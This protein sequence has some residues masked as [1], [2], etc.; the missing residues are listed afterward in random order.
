MRYRIIVSLV[1]LL[2]AHQ[3][4]S[5]AQDIRPEE[6]ILDRTAAAIRN[7]EPEWRFIGGICTCPPLVDEQ[8]GVAV[9]T[10]NRS[11]NGS[12]D[13]IS[14]DIYSIATGRLRRGWIYSRLHGNVAKGC[15]VTD[16]K[17]GDDA[18]MATYFDTSQG[19]SYYGITF[20][21]GRFVASINGQ[22]RDTVERFARFPLTAMEMSH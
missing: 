6:L 14:V 20:R 4:A 1:G 15:S 11:L 18:T 9:G 21:K 13:H 17:L 5:A 12:S 22:S 7:A 16:Y 19:L 8:L 3:V 10:L 2:T